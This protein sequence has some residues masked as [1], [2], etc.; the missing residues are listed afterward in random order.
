[1]KTITYIS[2]IL[3]SIIGFSQSKEDVQ[4][5]TQVLVNNYAKD[6]IKVYNKYVNSSLIKE[7]E[8][9]KLNLFIEWLDREKIKED[10]LSKDRQIDFFNDSMK[11]DFEG[12]EV[13]Y[14]SDERLEKKNNSKFKAKANK[15]YLT[16]KRKTPMAYISFPIV[17]V[18]GK[19]A[20]V[21]C[22]YLCGPLCGETGVQFLKK[23]NNRWI[24]V[25][26][27]TRSIS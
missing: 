25:K 21:Y 6:S 12:I 9:S 18:N 13:I 19:N 2:A 17:S 23:E 24:I 14:C 10:T 22:T 27:E 15:E 8:D 1:M 4:Q 3:I 16:R 20:I 11:F 26:Y 7:L 5:I